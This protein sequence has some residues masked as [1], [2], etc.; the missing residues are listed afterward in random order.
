MKQFQIAQHAESDKIL[1]FLDRDGLLRTLG[2]TTSLKMPR[3][4]IDM[5]P[6]FLVRSLSYY[7]TLESHI[8]DQCENEIVTLHPENGIP[9]SNRNLNPIFVSCW[10]CYQDSDL[11][12]PTTWEAFPDTVAA[13]ESVVGD[14]KQIIDRIAPTSPGLN[15]PHMGNW[16]SLRADAT[17]HGK[18]IYYSLKIYCQRPIYLKK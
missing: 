15:V 2:F 1:R 12:T 4:I 7:R 8:G 5:T 11:C 14:V 18:I 3:Q 9:L 16:G 17:F 6:S 13:I 10:S